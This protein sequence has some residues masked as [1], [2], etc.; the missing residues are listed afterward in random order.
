MV[1]SI[2]TR[3]RE[4]LAKALLQY[5]DL[6]EELAKPESQTEDFKRW[7]ANECALI[8]WNLTDAELAPLLEPLPEWKA[9]MRESIIL[10]D[11]LSIAAWK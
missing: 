10:L 4:L 1:Q 7:A 9:L 8:R 5:N 3:A 2:D 11:K 6:V